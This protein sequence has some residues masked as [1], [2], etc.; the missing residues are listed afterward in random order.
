MKSRY[1]V[2][3]VISAA[4]AVVLSQRAMAGKGGDSR[5]QGGIPLRAG[6]YSATIQ[7]SV[8]ICL[9]PSTFAQESCSTSG[10]LAAPLSDL[11]NGEF[12]EDGSG[13]SCAA[14]TEVDANLPVNASPPTVTN[15]NT[16]AKVLDYD[17]TT[18]TGDSSFTSYS[19][20][21][22]QR[23]RNRNFQRHPPLRC[24]RRRGH[25]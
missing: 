16:V 5:G 8:A 3:L 6:Q 22:C 25:D 2:L 13:N 1:A 12:T 4:I 7:G 21:A 11:E 15:V 23:Q 20:G 9:N 14:F 17:S 18:G 19:G 10:A 24:N